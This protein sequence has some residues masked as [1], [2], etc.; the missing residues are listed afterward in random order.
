M[1]TMNKAQKLYVKN[2]SGIVVTATSILLARDAQYG[3]YLVC[4]QDG[5]RAFVEIITAR[6]AVTCQYRLY[7]DANEEMPTSAAFV[8]QN[9]NGI[10]PTHQVWNGRAASPA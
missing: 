9:R 2:E 5:S 3:A 4:P 10:F 1:R 6:A 7:L 8:A